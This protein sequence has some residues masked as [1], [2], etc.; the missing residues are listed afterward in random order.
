M[1]HQA[2]Q[3]ETE[4]YVPVAEP[5]SYA[6]YRDPYRGTRT[7][8]ADTYEGPVFS[9]TSPQEDIR[10][11]HARID[12]HL[13]DVDAWLRLVDAQAR[14]LGDVDYLTNSSME[15][16]LAQ[17]KLAVLERAIH[18]AES[19]KDSL[20]LLLTRLR[21]ASAGGIWPDDQVLQTWQEL[22]SRS[23]NSLEDTL[24]LWRNY[25]S[26]R[27]SSCAQV[28]ELIQVYHEAVATAA[29]LAETC[30][31]SQAQH[32]EHFRIDTVLEFSRVLQSAG[33]LEWGFAV[34]QALLE[35]HLCVWKEGIPDGLTGEDVLD[36]FCTWWDEEHARVSN[37]AS[38]YKPFS[39]QD[40]HAPV[41]QV[42]VHIRTP[43]KEPGPVANSAQHAWQLN[44]LQSPIMPVLFDGAHCS[45]PKVDPYSYVV[46]ADI[47]PH[48]YIPAYCSFECVCMTL[49]AFFVLLGFPQ[50]WII[51]VLY[52][53]ETMPAILAPYTFIRH[54]PYPLPVLH[55]LLFPD[56]FWQSIPK[57]PFE[58][59]VLYAQLLPDMLIRRTKDPRGPWFHSLPCISQTSAHRAEVCLQQMRERMQ[60]ST[61]LTLPLVM[62]Y[63]AVREYKQ[64]RRVVRQQ[65]QQT[66]QAT[67]LWYVYAQLELALGNT[68]AVH[69]VG[70]EVLSVAHKQ[71]PCTK[72]FLAAL[73]AAWVEVLW[74][75]GA[76]NTCIQV[77]KSAVTCQFE[78]GRLFLSEQDLP[79]PEKL[80]ILRALRNSVQHAPNLANTY[81]LAIIVHILED[82]PVGQELLA[83]V[84]VFQSALEKAPAEQ[85]ASLAQTCQ[86]FV[87]AAQYGKK[88]SML[89]PRD[90]RALTTKLLHESRNNTI[91]LQMLVNQE[92]HARIDGYAQKIAEQ[93]VLSDT[94]CDAEVRWM[95]TILTVVPNA[96]MSA[97]RALFNR[98]LHVAPHVRAL[99]YAAINWEMRHAPDLRV[100]A[101][102][103]ARI[104]ALI[105]QAM[106]HCPYDKGV[107]LLSMEPALEQAFTSEE[108]VTIERAGEEHQLRIL[109]DF[110]AHDAV[111]Q[112][113]D[114]KRHINMFLEEMSG[115]T[116]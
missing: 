71:D 106:R 46:A 79:S 10:A 85:R 74:S 101:A 103:H 5:S 107:V 82:A 76:W 6:P 108:T 44:E 20:P 29:E 35:L 15:T 55:E 83:S 3:E 36:L 77:A 11:L 1:E 33:Y 95:H 111:P 39:I 49:D 38:T 67:A 45:N 91:L 69:R 65:L 110:P 48:L 94:K 86:R 32:I 58:C 18:A 70:K 47:R 37:D 14:L 73:W 89:R 115:G 59:S 92:Q 61:L 66:P 62:L 40:A 4:D 25:L 68:A 52:L 41:I 75:E 56:T 26:F 23:G 113:D 43:E 13:D 2:G 57:D 53:G 90:S 97:M 19:N 80:Q 27:K 100:R 51:S 22:L 81:V 87:T 16:T 60:A 104:K 30:T 42:S 21:V 63:A 54:V 116:V 72:Y 78:S 64:A 31:V 17:M 105:Y 7:P 112:E 102:M 114:I 8:S 88:Q 84:Q 24:L 99:W 109:A 93:L 9:L 50:G 96:T 98:A 12:V 28:D 34:L